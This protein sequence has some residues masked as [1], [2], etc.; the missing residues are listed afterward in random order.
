MEY[1][2]P[3]GRREVSI[4]TRGRVSAN[5][6]IPLGLA[7]HCPPSPTPCSPSHRQL[8]RAMRLTRSVGPSIR[9]QSRAARLSSLVN[10]QS[11]RQ[12]FRCTSKPVYDQCILY[13]LFRHIHA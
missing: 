12:R 7:R 10:P 1:T 8:E 9:I 13:S 11:S 3:R 6:P 4:R 5:R 2:I